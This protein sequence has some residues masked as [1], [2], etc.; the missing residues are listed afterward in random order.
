MGIAAPRTAT[1]FFE[2]KIV[3][4]RQRWLTGVD[5]T[6]ISLAA[7]GLTTGD[8]GPTWPVS[9]AEVSRQTIST[10]TAKVLDSMAE[11]QNRPLDAP[12]VQSVSS[13]PS[14]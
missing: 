3:K 14:T 6:V 5:K 13:T 11:W 2:P 10:I 8:G 7:N 4:K 9:A 1:A 12:S